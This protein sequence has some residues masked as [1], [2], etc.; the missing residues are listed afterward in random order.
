[1]VLSKICLVRNVSLVLDA[2]PRIDSF[3]NPLS[4][5]DAIPTPISIMVTQLSYLSFTL[6]VRSVL[7]HALIRYMIWRARHASHHAQ[8]Q[9][10]L[11][12]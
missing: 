3:M 1:M 12:E 7:R 11:W 10:N 6:M 9:E 4:L 8:V 5:A 2:P